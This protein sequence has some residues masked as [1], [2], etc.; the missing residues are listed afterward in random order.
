MNHYK[1]S[2]K[3]NIYNYG[4]KIVKNDSQQN[5]I[6]FFQYKP[7]ETL[8]NVIKNVLIWIYL[9]KPTHIVGHSMGGYI[10]S[11]IILNNIIDSKIIL[12]Q[13]LIYPYNNIV[14]IINYFENN[15]TYNS[16]DDLIQKVPIGFVAPLSSLTYKT[17]IA[18][19]MLSSDFTRLV[20]VKQI[21]ESYYY[22]TRN[23]MIDMLCKKKNVSLMYA[24]NEMLN[25]LPQDKIN[26]LKNNINFIQIDSKH[27]PFNDNTYYW[28]LNRKTIQDD[29]FE[30]FE[31][32]L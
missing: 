4:D 20:S 23:N 15:P 1:S 12:L 17:S 32:M 28:F 13:P 9:N 25:T 29:F 26:Q 14:R 31:R 30:K 19:D 5:R 8:S 16:N 10:L 21:T 27:E 11:R 22:M 7:E 2:H 18:E 6:T 24:S 3:I